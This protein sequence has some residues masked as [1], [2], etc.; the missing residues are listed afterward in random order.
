M[1]RSEQ[2]GNGGT[3]FSTELFVSLLRK[4]RAT[5]QSDLTLVVEAA[6]PPAP[7]PATHTHFPVNEAE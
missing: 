3:P 1:P 5:W 6:P 7:R 4:G 2:V